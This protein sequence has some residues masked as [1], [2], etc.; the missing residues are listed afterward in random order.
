LFTLAQH[1][2]DLGQAEFAKIGDN[3]NQA[4]LLSNAGR[5]MRLAALYRCSPDKPGL[6]PVERAFYDKA[7]ILYRKGL[8]VLGSRKCGPQVWDVIM[9]EMSTTLFT[10]ATLYQD[11]PPAKTDKSEEEVERELTDLLT[12]ALQSCDLDTTDFRQCMYQFRAAMLHYRLGSLYQQMYRT[13]QMDESKRKKVLHL[14]NYHYDKSELLMKKLEHPLEYLRLQI[15][16]VALQEL[17]AER[18]NSTNTKLK[19]L[20][21]A[22]NF[23]ISCRPVLE[24]VVEKHKSDEQQSARLSESGDDVSSKTSDEVAVNEEKKLLSLYESRIQFILKSL[25]KLCASTSNQR[26]SS[27][28]A[29]YKE[30]Y[31]IVL[32]QKQGTSL[33]EHLCTAIIELDRLR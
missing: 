19:A 13:K 31:S 6:Q 27:L 29:K 9:W 1:H 17:I 2:L 4:L 7:L 20:E 24:S 23:L 30:M 33:A 14:V 5:L 12:K 21:S 18:S 28:F 32:K 22:L 25:V 16:R 26:L 10:M 8:E 3:Y 11:N 15:E